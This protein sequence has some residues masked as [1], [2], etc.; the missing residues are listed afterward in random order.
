VQE[1][2]KTTKRLVII[3]GLLTDTEPSKKRDINEVSAVFG[4]THLS[5]VVTI[6]TT[7]TFNNSALCPQSAS[8]FLVSCNSQNKQESS[9]Y[10][11]LITDF[12]AA[13][14]FFY[15]LTELFRVI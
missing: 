10:T 2:W 12:C 4:L 3:T 15:V 8:L 11:G 7:L 9:T 14:A 1:P 6:C 13:D 5:T